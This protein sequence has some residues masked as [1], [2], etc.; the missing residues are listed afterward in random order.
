MQISLIN[1]YCAKINLHYDVKAL[2]IK[3]KKQNITGRAYYT[4]TL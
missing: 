3:E 2:F 4:S 1:F